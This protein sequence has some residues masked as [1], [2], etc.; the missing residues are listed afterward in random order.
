VEIPVQVRFPTST[1]LGPNAS[2]RE[3]AQIADLYTDLDALDLQPLWTQ[4]TRLL[5]KEPRPS[6]IPWLWQRSDLW[7]MADRCK[8]LITISRGGDRRVIALANP[9][10]DGK[11][12]A[13]PTLWA[14]IQYLGG[15]ESAPGHRHTPAAVRFVIEG[16]GTF[17]TVDGDA[18]DMR[19]GDLILTPPW[20]F[21]DH[22][23]ESDAPMMWFDGLDLPLVSA[24]DGIF[25]EQFPH[26]DMQPVR[27]RNISE[28]FYG[29]RATVPH[30]DGSTA[31]PYSPLLVYR[32]TDTSESLAALLGSSDAPMVSL[33]YVNPISG[34]SVLPTIGCH[35]HR[36]AG[37]G[38]S[39]PRRE[40]GSSVFVVFRGRGHSIINGIKFAWSAGDIFVVPSWACVE[41]SADVES[42]LFSI[43]DRPVMK[44]LGLYREVV[45][46]QPQVVTGLFDVDARRTLVTS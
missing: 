13:T 25:F 45:E 15:G 43:T 31:S 41:H 24:L 6:A 28:A 44:A 10:L 1:A 7:R 27:G 36:L 8:D 23:N 4:N 40:V 19:A 39:A 32:Y 2:E 20:Q 35:A 46:Q 12:F 38:R 34:A 26:E 17:T 21:H 37:K 11:P 16:S 3:I 18:C 14:A 22:A 29:G 9:G 5:T 30:V 42:D 33:E